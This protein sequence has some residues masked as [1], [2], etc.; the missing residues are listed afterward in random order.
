MNG[1]SLSAAGLVTGWGEGTAALPDDARV[2]AAG[3][4]VIP[5]P[6]P[7][8]DADRFRRSL[9]EGLLAV[10]AMESLLRDGGLERQAIA[11]SDTALLYVTA[12]AYAASNRAFLTESGPAVYFPYTAASAVPAEVTI[13]FGLT[14]GYI[15]LIGGAPATL[16]ALR[17]A[18][19]LLR[20]QACARALVLA[21]ETFVEC[22]DF[23]AS[24]RWLL[25]RPLVE[26]A[27]CVLLEPALSHHPRQTSTPP[28]AL[29]SLVIRRAG[30][31]LA[32]APLIALA[33]ARDS[34]YDP[35]SLT[36]AWRDRRA[37]LAWPPSAG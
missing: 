19:R 18:A 6:R 3:R 12:G 7:P 35:V 34:H 33:L 9:H 10:A 1:V 21:V 29:E 30:E 22:A 26:A 2:A 16:A 15:I 28:E 17:Q 27:A 4:A 36:G 24:S 5:I 32:V 37:E 23:Y 25:R 13:E 11:R 8:R 20:G 14:G 31:T